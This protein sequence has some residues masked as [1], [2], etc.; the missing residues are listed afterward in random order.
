VY[1]QDKTQCL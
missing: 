1:D